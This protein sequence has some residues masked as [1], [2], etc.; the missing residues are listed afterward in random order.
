[1]SDKKSILI[2]FKERKKETPNSFFYERKFS[3]E[4]NVTTI[5][6]SDYLNKNSS[7]IVKKINNIIKKEKISVALFEG[8]HL[9]IF[10]T[11]FIMLIDS[12]VKKG[13]FLQ[14]DYMFH[15]INRITA[16]ACDFVLTACPLS[17]LKFKELGYNSFFLPVE[18]DGSIFKDYKEKKIYDVLFF[19]RVKNNR[20]HMVKYLKENG[21]NIMEC[22]PYDT[23]SDTPEKLAK[24][25]NKSKIVLNFSESDNK[26]RENNPLSHYKYYY[27]M[28][29]RVCFIGM[30]NS[31]CVS[32]YSPSNELIFKDNEIP[33][34][35][36]KVDCL[37]IIQKLI[38]DD[39]LL[40]NTT[41]KY[42]EKCLE[43]EDGN[44]IKKIKNFLETLDLNK[45]IN[46][47]IP[48]WYEY[49]FF[50]KNIMLRFRQNSFLS[51][52]SQI[53]ISIFLTN[54]KTKY[55]IPIFFSLGIF[56]SILFI[57]K[58]PLKILNHEKI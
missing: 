22:G 48:Y 30:C 58:Y 9:S 23:I 31:L 20:S 12:N 6:I 4:Y 53:F 52:F 32:E 25:I 34:F 41:K 2:L 55:L 10:D 57:I 54:Y 35:R 29:G 8:D 17:N 3:R 21:I 56:V 37:K 24:L 46:V 28:K 1:M 45:K 18:A 43:Y 15:F 11:K 38:K 7:S 27:Q 49:A 36:E 51:F 42:K 47:K 13:I 5:F 16:S 39:L 26:N 19:G 50:K 40:R 14:D 44:Y 33:Y